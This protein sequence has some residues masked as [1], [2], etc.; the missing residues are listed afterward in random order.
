MADIHVLY[1]DKNSFLANQIKIRLEWKGYH[2]DTEGSEQGLLAK[3]REHSYDLLIVDFLTPMPNAFSWLGCLKEQNI[4]L[5]P[6]II[7]ND[8]KCFRLITKA[9]DLGCMDYVV[10][11]PL[12]QNFVDQLST[13]I[14]QTIEK[15][16]YTEKQAYNSKNTRSQSSKILQNNATN[17]EYF[18]AQE[19]VQWSPTQNQKKYTL[20]YDEFISKIHPDDIAYVKTQNN[21]C[22]SLLQTVEYSFRYLFNNSETFFHTRIK[23]E[24]DRNGIVKRLYGDLQP[25]SSQH[26][27]DKNLH[28]KLSFLDNTADA[29]FITDAQKRIISV[30]DAFTTI[31]GYSE[32]EI[33][34]KR[35]YILNAEQFDEEFFNQV[36]EKLKKKNFWQGEVLIR[37]SNGH[38][39]PV[40]QTIYVLK[41][42]DGKISQSLTVLR[43]IGKQKAYEE[44]IIFQANYDPLTQ[45]PNR[46]LF[47]DRLTNAIKLTKRNNGKLALMLLDLNKFKWVNDTFGHYAGDIILQET[48]K[49]LKAAVRNSD[50]VARLGGDEFSIIVPELKKITDAELIARKIFNAFKQSVFIEQQEVFISGSIGIT[51]FPD[52]GDDI[53]TLQKNA[54]NAMYLAKNGGGSNSYCYYTHALQQETEKR[55]KLIDDMHSAMRNQE[56]SLHFQPIIDVVTKKVVSAETL[57]R[58]NHPIKGNVP[59]D[60]FIPVAEDSGLIHEIGNWVIDEVASNMKRWTVLGLPSFGISVNQ[61]VA[62]YGLSEC[63]IEWLDILKKQ[64]I[65]PSSITFEIPEKIFLDEKH[66]CLNSI[67]QLKQ[68]GIN[69][70]LDSFGTGYSSLSYLKKFPVDVIKIDRSCIRTMLDDPTNAILV[71]T[72]VVLAN[73]LGI[74]VIATGVENQQQL[75]LLEQKCRYVQGYYFSK[76]LPLNEFEKFL[77]VHNQM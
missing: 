9:M 47:L 58:W 15:L 33:L 25:F 63:H 14:F 1:L 60:D 62:Q 26:L 45:L 11:E 56:F 35:I 70:S 12:V 69:I 32:R 71:E 30:N 65:P 31:C 16:N 49:K 51:F 20:S 38:S 76:P 42:A 57:L 13:S 3:L 29:V 6:A 59:L 27:T 2:V 72:I 19:L 8:D 46:T 55:L 77:K 23:A 66:S 39:V 64:H 17:W 44:S 37:H 40:W 28:L 75:A 52:D 43:D 54:D 24:V 18:I 41:N 74:K 50:T 10:K 21:I 34:K 61:S 4:T 53:N 67:K 22:L 7:V 68:E 48:A 5:P 73:K 36:T